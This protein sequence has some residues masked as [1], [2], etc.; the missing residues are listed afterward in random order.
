MIFG[1]DRCPAMAHFFAA[2]SATAGLP[3]RML[4][5]ARNHL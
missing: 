3:L 2:A 4:A 5:E 1:K